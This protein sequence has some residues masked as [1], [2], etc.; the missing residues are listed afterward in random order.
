MQNIKH[1]SKIKDA[2]A[3]VVSF[4]D[5]DKGLVKPN[6]ENNTG[7]HVKIDG[8]TGE[9]KAGM[10]GKFDGKH[11]SQVYKEVEAKPSKSAPGSP[12]KP[13]RPAKEQEPETKLST[14]NAC[15]QCSPRKNTYRPYCITG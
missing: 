5:A 14:T 10:G 15:L 12:K 6:G 4:F 8:E 2:A 11:I 9:T 7:R 1:F 13:E 3:K